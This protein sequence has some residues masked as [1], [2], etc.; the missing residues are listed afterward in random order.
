MLKKN[1]SSV[2]RRARWGWSRRRASPILKTSDRPQW[3]SDHFGPRSRQGPHVAGHYHYELRWPVG[4][5]GRP[6]QPHVSH[7][8]RARPIASAGNAIGTIQSCIVVPPDEVTAKPRD[9]IYVGAHRR[10]GSRRRLRRQWY[11]VWIIEG[12]PAKASP[13]KAPMMW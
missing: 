9:H 6:R 1:R 3:P 13:M 12:R 10:S 7:E 4:V 2:V 5:L 11:L 8:T